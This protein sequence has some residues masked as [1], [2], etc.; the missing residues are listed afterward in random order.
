MKRFILCLLS[1]ILVLSGCSVNKPKEQGNDVQAKPIKEET[2]TDPFY[3]AM[4]DSNSRPVAFMI[5]NDEDSSRP[6]AG[7]EDAFLVYEIVVEGT[8]TRMMAL[9]K[10]KDTKLIGPIRSS[11]HY[12]LDFALENDAIYVHAGWS[13]KAQED[14]PALGVNNINGITGVDGGNFWRDSSFTKKWHTLYTSLPKIL[15]HAEDKRKYRMKSDIH[16]FSYNP[17]PVELNGTSATD[18]KIPYASFYRVSYLY[19]SEKCKYIRYVN[20]KKHT[21]QSG[22]DLEAEN[23]IILN[24]KNYDLNDGQHKQRQEIEDVGS[25]SGYYLTRGKVLPITWTKDSRTAHSVYAYE[26]GEEITL[27][28]GQTWIQLVPLDK[29]A[30][31]Q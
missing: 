25:G 2:K 7:L 13:P 10:D 30:T 3:D 26:N 24:V 20:E 9:F 22:A 18:I 19:D 14:I 5:D 12:F 6:Q 4:T 15:K 8:A 21:M 11:R 31:I 1:L 27:N 28:P 29:A 23:I 17:M 16:N